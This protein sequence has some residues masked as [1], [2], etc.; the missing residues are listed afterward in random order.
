MTV[1]AVRT[2]KGGVLK[3]SITINLAGA[4]ATEGKKVL[5]VDTDNQGNV[6]LS[7]GLNPD[8]VENTIYDVLLGEITPEEAIVNVH[9]YIDV[10]PAN[11][12]MSFFEMDCLTNSNDYPE[13]FMLLKKAMA[14]LKKQYDYIFIDS[15]PT[16][17]LVQGNVLSFVDQVLIPFQPESYSMRSLVKI[18]KA[19]NGIKEKQNPKLSI[20]GIVATLVDQRTTLHSEILQECRRFCLEQNIHMFDTVIPRSV[21]FASSVAYDRKPATLT[22]K[23]NAIVASYFELLK[24]VKENGEKR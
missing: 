24:E 5:I 3:T 10:I 14:R 18:I 8:D 17:G 2:N 1:I 15:P 23:N 19:I 7:F 13:P 20:A 12:D 22:D 21:R 6:L 4:L 9:D 11:D 16:L